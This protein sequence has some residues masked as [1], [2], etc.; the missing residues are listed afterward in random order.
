[1]Q[2]SCWLV[3]TSL[4]WCSISCNK[5]ENNTAEDCSANAVTTRQVVNKPAVV[6]V[7]ATIYSIYLVEEGSMDLKLVPCDFLP[8][9]FIQNDLQVIISGDVKQRKNNAD[10]CCTENIKITSLKLR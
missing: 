3:F 6:K 5:R 1:M 10:P 8:I 4:I 7:T 9:E 2:K